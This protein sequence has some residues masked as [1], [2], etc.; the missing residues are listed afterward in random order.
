MHCK[1]FL[2]LYDFRLKIA[3]NLFKAIKRHLTVFI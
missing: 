1:D 2:F 3:N